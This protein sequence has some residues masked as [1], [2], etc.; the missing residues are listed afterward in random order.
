LFQTLVAGDSWGYCGIDI[1]LKA[2]WAWFLFA[3]SL[4]SIQLGFTNLILAVIVEKAASAHEEDLHI[5]VQERE[6]QKKENKELMREICETIDRDRNG[7]LTLS[8]LTDGFDTQLNFQHALIMLDI[9]REDLISF[10]E[11]VDQDGSGDVSY[12]ELFQCLYKADHQDVKRQM[13]FLKLQLTKIDVQMHKMN[14][15]LEERV[16]DVHKD[17]VR[18][19]SK[20]PDS[21]IGQ[22][23]SEKEFTSVS[24]PLSNEVSYPGT[25]SPILEDISSE[26]KRGIAKGSQYCVGSSIPAVVVMSEASSSLAATISQHEVTYFRQRMEEEFAVAAQ[27]IAEVLPKL[28]AMPIQKG[29]ELMDKEPKL[30]SGYRR[31]GTVDPAWAQPDASWGAAQ[32]PTEPGT[33]SSE[34]ARQNCG[35]SRG[36]G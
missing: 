17:V 9:E 31:D 2:P 14:S 36:K 32:L 18:L 12:N 20:D 8:E 26:D 5:A 28:M 22:T 13:M 25:L 19:H 15:F 6:E 24:S 4:C 1:V 3:C 29:S 34:S 33:F 23:T 16:A 30:V 11:L 27:R 10:F 21:E 35:V 7:T